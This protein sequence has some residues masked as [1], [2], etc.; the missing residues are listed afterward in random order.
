MDTFCPSSSA[1]SRNQI[2]D[3]LEPGKS[4]EKHTLR[5][6]NLLGSSHLTFP[7]PNYKMI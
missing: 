7:R 4:Q 2:L 6:E 5:Y 3:V 1:G